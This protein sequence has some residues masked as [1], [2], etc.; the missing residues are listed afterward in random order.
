MP[1]SSFSTARRSSTSKLRAFRFSAPNTVR[2]EG[3]SR[4]SPAN[5]TMYWASLRELN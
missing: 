1:F 4:P 3:I 5:D 2:G